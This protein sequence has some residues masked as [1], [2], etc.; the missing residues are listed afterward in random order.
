MVVFVV[1]FRQFR[2]F[3]PVDENEQCAIAEALSDMDGLLNALE[4]LIAKKQAIKQAT[5]QQLLTGKT[6]LPGFS[7]AWEMKP[8]GEIADCLDNVRVPL[9]DEQRSIASVLSD[10]DAEIAALEERRDKTRAIKQGIMQQL[11]TGR[12][13]L[14]E[15]RICTDDTD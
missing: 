7:G 3:V 14:S 12:V 11:L 2:L 10:M 15:S 4:A 9:I 6:R 1:I 5:M 8:L 13:R